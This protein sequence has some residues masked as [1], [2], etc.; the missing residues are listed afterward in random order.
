MLI[1][2]GESRAGLI[3]ESHNYPGFQDINGKAQLARLREQTERYSAELL[4]G[5]VTKLLC[6]KFLTS[7]DTP[8]AN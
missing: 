5:G 4:S 1:D 2:A 3:P 6:E 7:R 8:A